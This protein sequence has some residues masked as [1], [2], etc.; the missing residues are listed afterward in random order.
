MKEFF[1]SRRLNG[2]IRITLGDKIWRAEKQQLAAYIVDVCETYLE[3]GDTLT[4]RQLYY[5][6]VARDVI[7]NHIKAY[8]K[9]GAIKDDLV[10][11][12]YLD[13][14][15]FEDRGRQPHIAYYENSVEGSLQR[16]LSSYVLNRQ[17]GQP[18]AI[19]VWSEKDAI[20]GILKSVTDPYTIRLVINKGYNSSTSMHEA[21]RRFAKTILDD[22]KVTILYFGDHDPSGLDMIRDIRDRLIFMLCNG[23]LLDDK[24]AKWWE[25]CNYSLSDVILSDPKY[26]V[27][28]DYLETEDIPEH[29]VRLTWEGIT[30]LFLEEKEALEVKHIGLTQEQIAKYNPPPNPAKIKDPRAKSY[31]AKHG[32]VS[33]EVDALSPN[34]MREI[35]SREIREA[36]DL[37]IYQ[38]VL[39]RELR[40]RTRLKSMIEKL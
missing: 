4:L 33:W 27:I 28:Y 40:D 19:E 37:E 15:V 39:E 2:N 38:D 10:Y 16:T 23:E 21:Y 5:Q 36:M 18:R 9:I 22:R 32:Q 12:G 34:V 24:I 1:E 14:S 7:P 25:F 3:N 11:S 35:V 17:A 20:S 26:S 13:W 6:L 29:V 30:S 31:I 8:K